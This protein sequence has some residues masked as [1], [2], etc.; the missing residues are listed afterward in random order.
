VL[1]DPLIPSLDSIE[2]VFDQTTEIINVSNCLLQFHLKY[3]KS[4]KKQPMVRKYIQLTMLSPFVAIK[5]LFMSIFRITHIDYATVECKK[6]NR[7]VNASSIT[8][9]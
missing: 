2:K 1:Y 8:N 7:K 6:A 3:Q 9:S 4:G 5:I